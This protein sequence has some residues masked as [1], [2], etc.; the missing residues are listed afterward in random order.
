MKEDASYHGRAQ[1]KNTAWFLPRPNKHKYKGG[2]PLF[3]E[4]WLVE[5]ALDILCVRDEDV[6]IL[7]LFCGM[8]RYGVRVDLN[9]EVEP[10][11]LLDAHECSEPLLKKEGKFDIILADPPYSNKEAAK[12]YSGVKL[13]RL[14]YESW[15]YECERLMNPNG[16]LIVYHK[17]LMPNP[18]WVKFRIV[19][20]VFVASRIRHLPRIAVYFQ[21][22][23]KPLRRTPPIV[24]NRSV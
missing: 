14:D 5:L 10:D 7:N 9:P 18:N 24:L 19:K 3:C 16:L 6:R 20:R 12:L 21:F 17:F 1:K 2:M 23:K 15:T 13:P 8:N 4:K 22:K 11:Y